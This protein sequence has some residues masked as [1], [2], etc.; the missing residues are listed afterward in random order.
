MAKQG[1]V[2]LVALR[3]RIKNLES[4]CESFKKFIPE[5]KNIELNCIGHF[6]YGQLIATKEQMEWIENLANAVE[7]NMQ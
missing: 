5:D 1:A 2:M 4:R 6:A 3:Q 7:R